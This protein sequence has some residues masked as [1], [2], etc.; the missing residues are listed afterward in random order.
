M[1]WTPLACQ[2]ISTWP[3]M[4]IFESVSGYR[5][6]V[7]TAH[8]VWLS[9]KQKSI[10]RLLFLSKPLWDYK[11]GEKQLITSLYALRQWSP[12]SSP[13]CFMNWA[14]QPAGFPV[15]SA[16]KQV[17]MLLPLP[18]CGA[19]P[20]PLTCCDQF[21]FDHGRTSG[22]GVDGSCASLHVPEKK[23]HAVT[24]PVSKYWGPLL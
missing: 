20:P 6:E 19:F 24:K 11:D 13:Q 22:G 16:P 4:L 1:Q 3:S 10:C 8:Q 15:S 18:P 9:S 7:T 23:P 2:S 14:A 21:C 17:H 12:T 5:A